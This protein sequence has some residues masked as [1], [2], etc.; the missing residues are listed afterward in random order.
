MLLLLCAL[1]QDPSIDDLLRR[2]A[3][4]DIASAR[5]VELGEKALAPLEDARKK[6]EDAELRG[7]LDEVLYVGRDHEILLIHA[8]TRAKRTIAKMQ[9]AYGPDEISFAPAVEWRHR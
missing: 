9:P 2:L 8:K 7:R 6:T 1:L 5:L 3:G 4:D